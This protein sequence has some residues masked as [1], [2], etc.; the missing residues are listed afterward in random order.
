MRGVPNFKSCFKFDLGLDDSTIQYS[1]FNISI[2]SFESRIITVARSVLYGRQRLSNLDVGAVLFENTPIHQ[3]DPDLPQFHGRR[4]LHIRPH[5]Y[6][7]IRISFLVLPVVSRR[8]SVSS[9]LH[10]LADDSTASVAC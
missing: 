6:D 2:S 9:L 1:I 10:I 8:T 5:K 7:L 3:S 4:D